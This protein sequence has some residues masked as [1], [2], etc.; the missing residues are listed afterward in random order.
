MENK[1]VTEYINNIISSFSNLSDKIEK[2]QFC[3]KAD[4]KLPCWLQDIENNTRTTAY[5]L[6]AQL[7]YYDAQD[8]KETIVHPGVIGS[9]RETLIAI[10][11][12]NLAK[13]S[14][15][16][17]MVELKNAKI[18][19]ND[20]EIITRFEAVFHE[21][22][23]K[24][25]ISA[26]QALR[27][28]GLSRLNLKQCYRHIP[29]VARKPYK[30]SWTWANTRAITKITV[31]KA[32]DLLAAKRQ[33]PGIILQLDKLRYLSPHKELAIVQELAPHL[34]ANIVFRDPKTLE[35]ERTMI[36]GPLPIFYPAE[37]DSNLP[38]FVLPKE[39]Q[40]KSKDRKMRSDVK[41]DPDVFL[42]ALRAHKYL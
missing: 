8:P 31:Q 4:H 22:L 32:A 16:K 33:D 27:K 26:S 20:P 17:H 3:I 40:G 35:T 21:S 5:K 42:P 36:K 10:N 15:K 18:K 41:I 24:R 25:N 39:K 7:E 9:S 37:E 30:I 11:E 14:F 29:T 38:F 2:L 6:I 28:T 12:V 23:K 1:S 19:I 13:D 34:R